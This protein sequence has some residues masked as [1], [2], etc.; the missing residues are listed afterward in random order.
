[1]M[2][3]FGAVGIMRAFTS[4]ASKPEYDIN[5]IKGITWGATAK[6]FDVRFSSG[7]GIGDYIIDQINF[8]ISC[9][10][11]LNIETAKELAKPLLDYMRNYIICLEKEIIKGIGLSIQGE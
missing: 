11:N 7:L 3:L 8:Q 2:D 4:K 1:M 10:D 9:Y 6:D 5:N